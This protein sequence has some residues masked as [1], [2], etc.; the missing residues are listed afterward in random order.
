MSTKHAVFQL[1]GEEYGLDI[2]QINTIEK[3]LD[4]VNVPNLPENVIGKAKLRGNDI[5]VYSLRKK[6]GLP[7]KEPDTGTRYLITDTGDRQVALEVDLVK[8]IKDIDQS[9]I[10]DVPE[11][12]KSSSTSYLKSIAD[13]DG[14]LILIIDNNLLLDDDEIKALEKR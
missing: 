6:F 10:F 12:V 3:D 11:V 2:T 13:T 1:N 8:G 7:D 5:P 9:D 4:I 14:D